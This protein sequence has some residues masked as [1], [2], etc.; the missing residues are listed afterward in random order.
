MPNICE[1]PDPSETFRP[2]GP[3]DDVEGPWFTIAADQVRAIAD[4]IGSHQHSVRIEYRGAAY[5]EVVLLD[6]EGNV[7]ELTLIPAV[8]R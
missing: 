6:P 5:W 1:D 3:E 8:V 7:G 4:V 2:S